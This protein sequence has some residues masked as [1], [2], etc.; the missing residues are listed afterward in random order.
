[1][2]ENIDLTKILEGCEGI[3]LWSPL[4]GEVTFSRITCGLLPCV[5]VVEAKGHLLSFYPDGTYFRGYEN[6]E[7]VLFPSKD[8]HDWSKFE[9]PNKFPESFSDAKNILSSEEYDELSRKMDMF[10]QLITIRNAWWKL[11]NDWKIDTSG[12]QDMFGIYCDFGS[13][14]AGGSKYITSAFMFRTPELRDMFLEKFR[15]ELKI[16]KEFI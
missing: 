11:D 2:N 6:A 5:E 4:F 3:K 13:I 12:N 16:C 10:I 14:T 8:Q 15:E 7:C 9:K 1:M